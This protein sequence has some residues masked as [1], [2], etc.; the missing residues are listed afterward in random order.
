MQG[1]KRHP[2]WVALL[3]CEGLESI[4]LESWE[5]MRQWCFRGILDLRPPASSCTIKVAHLGG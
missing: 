1:Q 5:L 4:L 3:A 2:V